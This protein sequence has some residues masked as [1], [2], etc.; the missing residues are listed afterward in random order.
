MQRNWFG[1]I[2]QTVKSCTSM[3]LFRNRGDL[4]F[5]R[6]VVGVWGSWLFWVHV[7]LYLEMREFQKQNTIY[8]VSTTY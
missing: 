7:D 4:G 2:E 8:Y 6:L 1:T 3:H 5:S